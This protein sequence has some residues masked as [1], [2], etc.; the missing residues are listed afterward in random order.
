MNSDTTNVL[1]PLTIILIKKRDLGRSGTE[2]KRQNLLEYE[3]NG[4]KKLKKTQV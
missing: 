2:E 4:D 1:Q 3:L